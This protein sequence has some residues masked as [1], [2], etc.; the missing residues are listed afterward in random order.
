MMDSCPVEV[1]HA[2]CA[3]LSPK[4]VAAFRLVTTQLAAIGVHYLVDKVRFH[5]SQCSIER[6]TKVSKHPVLSHSIKIL[7]WE[8]TTLEPDITLTQLREAMQNAPTTKAKAA[9][10]PELPSPNASLREQRLYRRNL[11]KWT[12]DANNTDRKIQSQFR[13]Y[14]NLL[15]SEDEA[16]DALLR[17][18]NAL[19]A[20]IRTFPRLKE[21]HFDN[22]PGKCQHM[23]SQR[24]GARF[25]GI[26]FPPLF[27]R[28]TGS[29]VWQIRD[30]LLGVA[31]SE[32]ALEKLVV[33]S[34]APSFFQFLTPPDLK[35]IRDAVS[36]LK[37]ISIGFRL[38]E[39]HEHVD[40]GGCFGILKRGG[41]RDMLAAS[42]LLE[43]LAVK[44]DHYPEG[45]VTSLINVLGK[46]VWP[47]LKRLRISHLSATKDE[48][49]DCLIRHS[50]LEDLFIGWMTL[51]KGTWE[52]TVERMQKELSLR[53]AEFE[54]FLESED[55][56]SP[57]F[58][59]TEM[60]SPM[61]IDFDFSDVDE[62]EEDDLFE[63][64]MDERE[65]LG[66]LLHAYITEGD[67]DWPNP[68]YAYDWTDDDM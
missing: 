39:D 22:E 62:M 12:C 13:K 38:D 45:G 49:M 65:H 30:L 18:S 35:Q 67:E 34:V 20:A 60:Y 47:R 42:P 36:S 25:D 55:S 10:K 24:F 53:S 64:M 48:L 43:N 28:D 52:D 31:Q 11:A 14:Q 41:L 6:L 63:A 59:N 32:S 50:S 3:L 61:P 33:H 29:T 27:D 4:D 51:K 1:L 16:K 46:V 19:V 58:W 21:I 17:P 37:Y 15:A 26:E 44:F 66:F 57:E 5:N 2:I 68:F 56:E 9:A 23:F 8:A 54:G 40:D 7:H